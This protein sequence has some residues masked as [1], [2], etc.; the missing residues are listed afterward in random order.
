MSLNLKP[1]FVIHVTPVIYYTFLH[2][3]HIFNRTKTEQF[4]NKYRPNLSHLNIFTSATLIFSTALHTS[5]RLWRNRAVLH[6]MV[7]RRY[8]Y[9]R[10]IF[11]VGTK[12]LRPQVKI[13]LRVPPAK[14]QLQLYFSTV[15]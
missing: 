2:Y 11:M 9:C 3:K 5:A 13:L 8:V 10:C 12:S 7:L 15:C 14:V 1:I 6:L 4:L